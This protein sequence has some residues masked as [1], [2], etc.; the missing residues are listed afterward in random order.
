MYCLNLQKISSVSDSSDLPTEFCTSHLMMESWSLRVTLWRTRRVP[1]SP[2]MTWSFRNHLNTMSGGLDSALH[3][4]RTVSNSKIL[5]D[6]ILTFTF[7]AYFTSRRMKALITSL[8]GRLWAWHVNVLLWCSFFGRNRRMLLV[9]NLFPS[10][11]GSLIV[12][13]PV[14]TSWPLPSIQVICGEERKFLFLMHDFFKNQ[15]MSRL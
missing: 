7:G 13:T 8:A 2:A 15:R 12:S 10:S 9:L 4:T 14:F 11:R 1:W 6:W 3:D 5:G